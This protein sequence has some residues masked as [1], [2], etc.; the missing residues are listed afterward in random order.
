MVAVQTIG[1]DRL[2]RP[3]LCPR[4]VDQLQRD[5]R[6]GAKGGIGLALGEPPLR[7]VR[8]D[9]QRIIEALV[10]PE[11]ADR[12]HA[13]LDLAPVPQVLPSHMGRLGPIFAIAG[14]IDDEH[15]TGIRHGAGI[16]AQHLQATRR[17]RGGVPRRLG[18]KPLQPLHRRVLGPDDGLG[19]G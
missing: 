16:G 9:G 5:L 2:E 14:F 11:T 17:H 10:R 19:M 7:R 18:E 8:L 1:D 13:I 4:L 15:P 12:D 3:G 6:F